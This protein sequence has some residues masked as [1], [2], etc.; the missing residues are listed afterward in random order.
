M[1]KGLIIFPLILVAGF[2][3][4]PL[5]VYAKSPPDPKVT[6]DQTSPY[7]SGYQNLDCS[8]PDKQATVPC[9][10]E[11]NF[12]DCSF[13]GASSNK[14]CQ[15]AT[16][17]EETARRI[18]AEQQPAVKQI[19]GTITGFVDA[20]LSCNPIT[21]GTVECF[22]VAFRNILEV[23]LAVANA[24]LFLVSLLFTFTIDKL[25]VNMGLYVT[26]SSAVGVQVAWTIMRDLANIAIIGGMIAISIGTILQIQTYSANKYLARLI[27][28]ALLV[29]FSYFFAGAI[30]DSSNYLATVMYNNVVCTDTTTCTTDN[31]ADRFGALVPTISFSDVWKNAVKRAE[32]NGF[33][34]KYGSDI[35][36]PSSSVSE[37]I[38]DLGLLIVVLITIMVLLSGAG[39]LLARFVTLILLLVS[40]PLGIAGGAIPGVSRFAREWWR[41]L[42]SQAFFAPVYFFLIG[43]SLR[44][45]D[46]AKTAFTGSSADPSTTS[47]G[48]LVTFAVAAVFMIMSLRVA[49]EMSA[50]AK[51]F[52][53][54]YKAADKFNSWGPSAYKYLLRS[55]G[56][57]TIGRAGQALGEY[58]EEKVAPRLRLDKYPIL[59]TL[60]RQL[61]KG[62]LQG[63]GGAKF[64]GKESYADTKTA[65]TQR[66]G[67]LSDK[68]KALKKEKNVDEAIALEEERQK[69][70]DKADKEAERKEIPIGAGGPYGGTPEEAPSGGTPPKG[71]T[72]GNGGGGSKPKEGDSGKPGGG[73]GG[74]TGTPPEK[75]PGGDKDASGGTGGGGGLKPAGR[76]AQAEKENR[77]GFDKL[78]PNLPFHV[79]L[80]SRNIPEGNTS[81]QEELGYAALANHRAM[82]VDQNG[83]QIGLETPAQV[84]ERTHLRPANF[85]MIDPETGKLRP[86]TAIEMYKQYRDRILLDAHTVDGSRVTDRNGQ[87]V[88]ENEEQLWGRLNGKGQ[89]G[90]IHVEPKT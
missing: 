6:N 32:T 49:K 62:L 90:I 70:L 51:R 10:Q 54:I 65:R 39:L 3:I 87:P 86:K 53:D 61:K 42:F 30:I 23:F 16:L 79:D 68:K 75:K 13:D 83:K 18:T 88:K 15:L 25:V 40:S 31:I 20:A 66:E 67:V 74:T 57:E 77:E 24:G 46:G 41:A 22:A 84:L 85:A 60:D 80:P 69:E 45:L 2:L 37:M 36:P 19:K 7:Y 44:I 1:K 9:Q 35:T 43:L 14:I 59:A 47:I 21:G 55:A 52:A 8:T 81:N 17:D 71:P 27:I 34:F 89:R 63:L 12:L 64:G 5:H 78:P 58:Y 28:A 50:E 56:T 76:R 4:T 29:N 33:N 82:Q 11:L 73:T 72:G 48:E 26:S 38:A